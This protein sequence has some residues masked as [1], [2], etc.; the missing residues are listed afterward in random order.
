MNMRRI[1]L[2]TRD[3]QSDNLVAPDDPRL[4]QFIIDFL[5]EEAPIYIDGIPLPS[6][7]RMVRTGIFRARGYGFAAPD[8]LLT[9]VGIMFQVAPN[10]DAQPQIRALLADESI[11]P[12]SRLDILT[13]ARFDAAWDEAE[14]AYDPADWG[15]R[16]SDTSE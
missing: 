5:D 2:P 7:Q 3:P 11:P 14:A 13:E 9:Y 15:P 16:D 6:L 10:F 4:I 8:D 12:E 1:A